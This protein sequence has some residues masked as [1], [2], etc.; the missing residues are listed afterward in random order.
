M[1]I[2]IN[3]CHNSFQNHLLIDTRRLFKQGTI[4][5]EKKFVLMLV[6]PNQAVL[7]RPV[8]AKGSSSVTI[9]DNLVSVGGNLLM[10][11]NISNYTIAFKLH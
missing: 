5:L 10:R 3:V 8:D 6:E 7:V 9:V 11:H 1:L 2:Q 4:I